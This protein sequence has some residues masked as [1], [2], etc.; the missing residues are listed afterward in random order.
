MKF[1]R[2]LLLG[3]LLITTQIAIAADETVLTPGARLVVGDKPD[4]DFT[5]L[6][7]GEA[8]ETKAAPPLPQKNP[9]TVQL[10]QNNPSTPI[11]KTHKHLFPDNSPNSV[12]TTSA[13]KPHHIKQVL[14]SHVIKLAAKPTE[15]KSTRKI[16]KH[17]SL[18]NHKKKTLTEST[19]VSKKV[20]LGNAVHS[21]KNLAVKKTTSKIKL[22]RNDKHSSSSGS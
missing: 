21:K 20:K 2:L 8:P 16:V 19:K 11:E 10:Q 15:V 13:L 7:A 14:P 9:I 3:A 6:H 4:E 12:T 1:S 5:I 17:V 18:S 22:A